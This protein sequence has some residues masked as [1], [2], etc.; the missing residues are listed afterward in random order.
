MRSALFSCVRGGMRPR[1]TAHRLNHLANLRRALAWAKS[2]PDLWLEC[3]VRTTRDQVL[4]AHHGPI[5]L[6]R[7]IDSQ[8][9]KALPASVLTLAEVLRLVKPSGLKLHLDVKAMHRAGRWQAAAK[10]ERLAEEL[11]RERMLDRVVISG[12]AGSFLRKLRQQAPRLS[13]GLLC[14]A[15]YGQPRP[16]TRLALERWLRWLLGFHREVGLA[17]VF[18]NQSWL[19]MFDLRW[20]LLGEFFAS[21]RTAGI[22]PM[23]WTVNHP[24][25]ARRLFTLGAS[26]LT[27]DRPAQLWRAL[28]N[29]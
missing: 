2:I 9:Q 20:H 14:D 21:L 12:P 1:L 4:V 25:W 15:A 26:R 10:A 8:R 28:T 23:V 24:V 5:C 27:T 6:G 16:R 3:D 7:R 22:S 11:K 19:R 17:A 13:L 29:L 18:L